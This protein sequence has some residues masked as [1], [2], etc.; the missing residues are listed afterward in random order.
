MSPPQVRN[1]RLDIPDELS[2]VDRMYTLYLQG[3]DLVC[4]SRYMRGG[5]L[6]GG[7]FFKQM[8]S[9]VSGLTLHY[10][11]GIAKHLDALGCDAHAVRLPAVKSVPE[12]AVP[13]LVA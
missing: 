13:L 1:V 4:G 10:F 12:T 8:M 5:Q 7:P 3:F 9:R 2:T 11:R 6:I